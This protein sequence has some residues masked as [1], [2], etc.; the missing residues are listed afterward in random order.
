MVGAPAGYARSWAGVVRP[1]AHN[2]DAQVLAVW[3]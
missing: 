3:L 2:R 1:W